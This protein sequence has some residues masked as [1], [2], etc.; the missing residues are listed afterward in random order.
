V[1][2]KRRGWPS[3]RVRRRGRERGVVVWEGGRG[4]AATVVLEK[5]A[6]R[7]GMKRWYKCEMR[8]VIGEGG[9]LG[10]QPFCQVFTECF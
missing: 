4:D 10:K 2:R 3:S 1:V 7:R 8:E 6:K 9:A 5:G